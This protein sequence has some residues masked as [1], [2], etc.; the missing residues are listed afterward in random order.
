MKNE[1]IDGGKPFDWGRTSPDYAKYRDIYPREFYDKIISRG[2]CIKGQNV[3]DL[4]T[5][6][7]VLPRNL[8]CF[9]AKWTG[10]DI[11]ANQIEQAKRLAHESDMRIDFITAAAEDID[12]SD[13]SYD[14]VTACQCFWYFDADKLVPKLYKALKKSGKLLLLYMAW[15]P[16]EDK[17]AY[18]S[19][20]LV[21]KYNPGW[22]GARETKKP[23]AIPK[24][25]NR[26]FRIADHEEYDL[27]VNFTRESWNGRMKTCR[28]VSA[29]LT[30]VEICAW[31][32]EH[33]E[34]LQKIAPERFDIAH[35][36]AF[37]VLQ[38]R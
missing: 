7:G 25:L 4:G 24:I 18:E 38:K 6:T 33:M 1:N 29:S 20:K 9:G 14:V 12:F 36:A 30:D 17:I 27:K 8:Y 26:Y 31:E 34:M 10:V 15:L 5:G 28:G 19:E 11:S 35:Y 23:I 3:L 2:L 37:T 13:D 32:K 16:F 21:L 22:S